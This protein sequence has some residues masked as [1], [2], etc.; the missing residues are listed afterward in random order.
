MLPL[1]L[2][3]HRLD[4]F[5]IEFSPGVGIR[6]YGLAYIAGFIVAA[7]LIKTLA[8]RMDTPLRP[9]AVWD[10]ILALAIGT[11]VG[12]RLGYCV[13]YRPDLLLTFEPT[14]PFWAV[15]AVNQGGMASH[16]GIIGVVLAVLIFARRR[17]IPS[18]HLMDM[19]AVGAPLGLFFGRVA[20]FINGELL[21]RPASPTLP[22]AVKFPHEILDWHDPTSPYHALLTSPE[23][24]A[25]QRTAIEI[26]PALRDADLTTLHQIMADMSHTSDT[27]MNALSPILPARHPSQLYA[28]GLEGLVVFAVVMIVWM[29]PRKPG[30]VAGFF[31]VT[32]SLMRIL[33][34]Q[35]RLPDAHIGFQ[36]LGLTRG[37]WLSLGLLAVM[38]SLLLYWLLRPTARIGG[39]LRKPTALSPAQP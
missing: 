3:F 39:W 26:N 19:A 1:A 37:Q 32:Y 29:Y 28:A 33:S 23:M 17:Q 36:L 15:L 8:R 22:W 13:F 5:A 35:F 6:W 34:E 12:G 30:V 27:M 21:G 38:G 7:L 9:A 20:N 4:P 18:L 2:Y 24:L 16:G 11:I 14:F 25:A 10:F 31:A